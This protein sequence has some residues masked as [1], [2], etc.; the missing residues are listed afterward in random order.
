MSCKVCT[1]CNE[2]KPLEAF[3]INRATADGLSSRCKACL[4]EISRKKSSA[5]KP[6]D[7]KKKTSNILDYQRKWR[8]ENRAR[9]QEYKE[10]FLLKN[11]IRARV[12][13][14]TRYAIKIGRLIR[15]P[16]YVCGAENAHAHH[17]DYTQ[18]LDV[19]WLCKTHHAELHDNLRVGGV[20]LKC[21]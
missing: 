2:S 1:F 3:Y 13:N 4:R 21:E 15:Q 16:C 14:A 9:C 7:W 8:S 5:G 11:P 20:G 19:V 10:K 17:H 18:P 6:A 12:K